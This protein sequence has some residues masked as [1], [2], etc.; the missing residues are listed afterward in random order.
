LQANAISAGLA[1]AA[2][3]IG[4]NSATAVISV[5]PPLADVA[6]GIS[7]TPNPVIVNSNVTYTLLVTNLGPGNALLTTGTFSLAGLQLVSVSPSQGSYATN[8]NGTVQC[9]LGTV[10]NGYIATVVITAT[11][12]SVGALTNVWTVGTASSDTN[13]DNNSASAAVTVAY[14]APIIVAGGAALLTQGLAA[15]NGVANSN[16]TVT[17]AFTLNNVG[18]GPTT[19]LVATLQATNG[20]TPIT[21]SETYGVIPAGGSSAQAYTFAAKG[22]PGS[23]VIATLSL[24]DQ[25]SSLGSVF[26]PFLIPATTNYANSAAIIIPQY[27]AGTP[28]PSQILVSGLTN[29]AGGNLLISK[30]TATLNG[31]AH[32]FP[33]D[34][35][36]LLDSPSG[37]ELIMMGHAGGPYGATNLTL[38]FDDAATQSLP[39]G[40]L[41]SGVYVPTDYPPADLFPGLAAASG[42]DVMA[43]FNGTS[44]NGVW[45]LYV[46][47]DTPGDSGIITGGWS[48]GLTAVNPLL[49]ATMT[50]SPESV[51]SGNSLTYQI[52]VTNLGPDMANNVVIT[53]TLPASVTFTSG[54]VSQGSVTNAGRTVVCRLGSIGNGSAASAAIHVITGTAGVIVNTA[55]VSAA[56]SEL[57][58]AESAITDS[59]TVVAAPPSPTLTATN[60][61][62]GLQ[63]TLAGEPGE[64]YAIQI[65]SNLTTWTSVFSNTASVGSG[66]FIYTDVYTNASAR[67]YRAVFL[68]Q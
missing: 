56:S 41:V 25:A 42:S 43:L 61:A 33:H 68:P 35:N 46:Y 23:V 58:L 5:N 48:L 66:S 12:A 9:S 27:G 18:Q 2:F 55:T 17:V 40:Q 7:V 60:L 63:L 31:F 26:F 10:S 16:Q 32:S 45:S 24:M 22:A 28:Y 57:Y 19:N 39:A 62:G 4:D 3:S 36:V 65:S 6:A 59:T 49:A 54:A 44:A 67:F 13:L 53:D 14:P 11:A 29:L 15:P 38:T 64:K 50:N 52:T 1:S 30:V 34:V 8:T 37:Q 20:V 47:D 21:T 51:Y